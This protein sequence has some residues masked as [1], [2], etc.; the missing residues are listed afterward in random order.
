MQSKAENSI[1]NASNFGSASDN[2]TELT[3]FGEILLAPANAIINDHHF[4]GHCPSENC[5]LFVPF[6]IPTFRSF[7]SAYSA[8]VQQIGRRMDRKREPHFQ[9]VL[10]IVQRFLR[11]TLL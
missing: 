3:G 1:T 9:T 6:P 11:E 7:G 4:N 2:D 8:V 10:H 5:Q